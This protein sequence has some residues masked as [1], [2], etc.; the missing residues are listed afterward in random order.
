MFRF[1]WM[2]SSL[3]LSFLSNLSQTT[4]FSLA[5]SLFSFLTLLSLFGKGKKKSKEVLWPASAVGSAVQGG[6]KKRKIKARRK[7]F[8]FPEK[9]KKKKYPA[10]A[11]GVT[12]RRTFTRSKIKMSQALGSSRVLTNASAVCCRYFF[13]LKFWRKKCLLNLREREEW[14]TRCEEKIKTQSF[15]RRDEVFPTYAL[16]WKLHFR[17][18]N[19]VL[20][21]NYDGSVLSN[22]RSCQLSFNNLFIFTFRRHSRIYLLSR[23]MIGTTG[24]DVHSN[25]SRRRATKL[26]NSS[27]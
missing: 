3:F 14:R 17:T 21:E 13:C 4:F 8:F 22:G 19:M 24:T 26:C 15:H 6:G 10:R 9:S 12:F 1:V 27:S 5:F 25:Y 2:M 11:T 18:Q 16:N 7:K 23:K 20:H